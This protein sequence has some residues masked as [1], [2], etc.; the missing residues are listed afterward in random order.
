MAL[1][2]RTRTVFGGGGGGVRGGGAFGT[3]SPVTGPSRNLSPVQPTNVLTSG[4]MQKLGKSLNRG[5]YLVVIPT[6]GYAQLPPIVTSADATVRIRAH[7]GTIAGNVNPVG[8]C[9]SFEQA[10]AVNAPADMLNPDDEAIYPADNLGR[11]WVRGTPGDGVIASIRS[12]GDQA[13]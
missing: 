12:G 9:D 5:G 8:L 7:N 10:R 4:N 11:I 6:V 3:S 2:A 13:N 1:A